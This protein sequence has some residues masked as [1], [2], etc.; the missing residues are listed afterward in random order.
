MSRKVAAIRFNKT[1]RFKFTY[2]VQDFS[3]S[4]SQISSGITKQNVT[5]NKQEQSSNIHVPVVS[6]IR[7]TGRPQTSQIGDRP[8]SWK[9]EFCSTLFPTTYSKYLRL[10]NAVNYEKQ[11]PRTETF[12]VGLSLQY[13]PNF[14]VILPRTKTGI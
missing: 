1:P 8:D 4:I 14:D 9:D 13:E 2:K 3:K 12:K 6:F 7:Q 11:A 10:Q 5:Q